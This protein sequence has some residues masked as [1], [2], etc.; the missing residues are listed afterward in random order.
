M[1]LTSFFCIEA[2]KIFRRRYDV[3]T[4]GESV[5]Q[6]H[7]FWF[8]V[9]PDMFPYK[10]NE[11]FEAYITE[12]KEDFYYHA[13]VFIGT[14]TRVLNI[15]REFTKG[16]KNDKKNNIEV[17]LHDENHLN[18]YFFLHKPLKSFHQ[19]TAGIIFMN[20]LSYIKNIRISWNFKNCE[21]R[22]KK[23]FYSSSYF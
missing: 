4:P 17:V 22:E 12:G 5:A 14:P 11:S 1:K 9:I 6:L 19:N 7:T 16:I 23:Q 8:L 20:C 13:T 10:G 21:L 18:K 3:Q 15:I 2:D